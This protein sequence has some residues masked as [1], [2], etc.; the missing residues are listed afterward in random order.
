MTLDANVLLTAPRLPDP[1]IGG[2]L[3]PRVR[4][5][6][7]P[8]EG[9]VKEYLRQFRRKTNTWKE[10]VGRFVVRVQVKSLARYITLLAAVE[11]MIG[12]FG[13]TVLSGMLFL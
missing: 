11:C 12:Y 2:V 8:Q 10:I 13:V 6:K 7:R 9:R 1:M 5:T 3:K 4:P